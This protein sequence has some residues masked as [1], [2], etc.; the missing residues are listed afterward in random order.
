MSLLQGPREGLFLMSEVPLSWGGEDETVDVGH[1]HEL[2]DGVGS[3]GPTVLNPH[4]VG[5]A[6]VV[7]L[8]S[9][10]PLYHRDD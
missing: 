4:P 3:H 7:H 6:L 8:Q 10:N 9:P 2:V 5:R 1:G